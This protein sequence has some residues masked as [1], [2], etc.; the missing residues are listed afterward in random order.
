MSVGSRELSVTASIGIALSERDLREPD[1]LVQRADIAMYRAKQ[2]GKDRTV[3]YEES[4]TA[5]AWAR[6]D[7]ELA[8][9]RAVEQP[10]FGVVYQPIVDV[11][12]VPASARAPRTG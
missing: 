9:R 3:L 1:E 2:G 7:P 10:E 12:T 6:L 5:H 8:L 11:A 4:M